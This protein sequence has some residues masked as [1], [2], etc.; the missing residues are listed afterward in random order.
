MFVSDAFFMNISIAVTYI[1]ELTQNHI[2]HIFVFDYA[3]T[4]AYVWKTNEIPNN[5]LVSF[6]SF[7][8]INNNNQITPPQLSITPTPLQAYHRSFDIVQH[9]LK[10][11]NSFLVNLTAE[12]QIHTKSSLTEI[13]YA[14]S[15]PFKLCIDNEF[16]V[17]SPEPF[18]SIFDDYIQTFP[19]KGTIDARI[20][21]AQEKI[22]HNK[23]EMA[24][25]ATIV[26]LL[27]NDMSM[28]AKNV[29]VK[30]Y[31]YTETIRTS[32]TPLIQ[33]SSCIEG[34]I[35]PELQKKHGS[36]LYSMLPAGSICGAPKP[37]TLEIIQEAEIHDRGF[38][39]GVMGFS[40]GHKLESA[41]MIRFI[42]QKNSKLYYK[43]G[44]GITAQSN[45]NDEYN[46]LIQKI[47]VPTH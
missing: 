4:Q 5:V 28:I 7:S 14:S 6:P 37:K 45:K 33:V 8:N 3:L 13:F 21:N 40:N 12:T 2:P 41:V 36:I 18:I 16:V 1:N 19:M 39:T 11:G 30:K 42:Q 9:H 44:G 23:K 47:Y 32:N 29:R 27:R 43:S 31:R 15:A 25:H 22:L 35:L 17:F 34:T 10:R 20:D 24:E 26:D 38:Y 46:E